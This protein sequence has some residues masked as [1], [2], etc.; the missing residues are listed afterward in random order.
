MSNFISECI[1]G[2]TLMSEI[3]DYIESWHESDSSLSLHE[4]LG[5]SKKEYALFVEDETYLGSIIAAHKNK[6]DI[7]PMMR[8]EFN[9]AA[10]S[11]NPKKAAQLQKWL[12][13][14]KLWE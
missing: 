13:R 8:E 1:K 3:N 2:V 4:F 6:V 9:L 11:D 10:R 14:E 7:V 5:M 12:D